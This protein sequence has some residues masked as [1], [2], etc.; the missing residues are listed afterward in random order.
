MGVKF[1]LHPMNMVTEISH[2]AKSIAYSMLYYNFLGVIS[3]A[4]LVSALLHGLQWCQ[5]KHKY[6]KVMEE[7]GNTS[8][9]EDVEMKIEQ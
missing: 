2:M 8:F 7:E 9:P 1:F 6:A 5:K 4:I 3:T